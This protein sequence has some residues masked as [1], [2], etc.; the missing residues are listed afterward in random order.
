MVNAWFVMRDFLGSTPGK[1]SFVVEVHGA[2]S[3]SAYLNRVEKEAA[4][5]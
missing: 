3:Q 4:R 1:P 5:T 2:F